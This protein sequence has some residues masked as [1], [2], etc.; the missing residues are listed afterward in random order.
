MAYR[1]LLSEAF[2]NS[3]PLAVSYIAL[4]RE[5][6]WDADPP[7]DIKIFS[8]VL[9]L[10][11]SSR[12]VDTKEVDQKIQCEDRNVDLTKCDSI[13]QNGASANSGDAFCFLRLENQSTLREIHQFKLVSEPKLSAAVMLEERGKAA[14]P[15]DIFL[16]YSTFDN[17]DLDSI[18]PRTGV[19]VK[20]NFSE[21]FG[22]FAS[23]AI[24]LSHRTLPNANTSTRTQLLLLEGIGSVYADRI[25]EARFSRPFLDVDD[26]HGRTG[27]PKK[28]LNCFF[29]LTPLP[30][31]SSI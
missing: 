28:S 19:V 24:Y 2:A 7:D 16:I 3:P 9:K 4:H 27:I 17:V 13:I 5:L 31:T 14:N 25:I 20:S 10:H 11:Q 18:P 21:Y 22:P 6:L 26:L 29:V 8:T 1:A 12:Q 30:F 15:D 23:R